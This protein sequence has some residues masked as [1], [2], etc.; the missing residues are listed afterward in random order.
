[1]RSRCEREEQRVMTPKIEPQYNRKKCP[2][3]FQFFFAFILTQPYSN[4]TP[5]MCAARNGRLEAAQ[6]LVSHGADMMV[7]DM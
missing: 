2:H 7:K 6:L 3:F 4:W 5:L 1:M